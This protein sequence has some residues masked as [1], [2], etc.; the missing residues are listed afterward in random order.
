[1]SDVEYDSREPTYD[2]DDNLVNT[3]D[4]GEVSTMIPF[5]KRKINASILKLFALLSGTTGES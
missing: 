4:Y 1:M 3:P 5:S 2:D